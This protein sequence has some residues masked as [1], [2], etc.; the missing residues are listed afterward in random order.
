VEGKGKLVPP[1]TTHRLPPATPRWYV[2]GQGQT[3]V[4]LPG[5]VEF[6][7]GSPPTEEG[8]NAV[9]LQHRRRIG[10]TFALAA[11]PVTVQE[12]RRFVEANQLEAWFEGGGE[13]APLMKRYNPSENGPAILVD[14]YRAAAYCNWLSEREGIPP[15]QWCYETNAQRLSQEK[16]SATVLLLLQGHPL[17]AAASAS[18]F[19]EDRQPQVTGLRKDYLSLPGY[20]LPTEAEWEYACRAGAVTIRSYGEMEDLLPRYGWYLKD[21]GDRTWPVGSKKPNDLG[22]FDMH[23]NVF[24]WC[25]ERF[26]GDYPAPKDGQ[27]VD[28]KED[29]LSISSTG[30]RVLRG[31]S[32]G[33]QATDVRC[34]HRFGLVPS[35]RSILVGFRP[36]RTITP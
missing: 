8:R 34:A 13:V 10:R 31:G 19:L 32:F 17:R 24:S 35:L 22:L 7:M 36:A 6:L 23:G 3:M 21:S 15:E 14:W 4:V 18:Y 26:Y 12:F 28:D 11:K 1:P 20:R 9:E 27:I 33:D 2:N 29:V 5:P 16:V 25:Q 30:S